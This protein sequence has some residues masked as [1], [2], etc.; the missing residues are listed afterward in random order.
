M[1]DRQASPGLSRMRLP[2]AFLDPERNRSNLNQNELKVTKGLSQWREVCCAYCYYNY[3]KKNYNVLIACSDD[4]N[5]TQVNDNTVL[6]A[7]KKKI[8]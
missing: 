5:D 8:N 3:L 1:R 6:I 7:T 2:N 4:N